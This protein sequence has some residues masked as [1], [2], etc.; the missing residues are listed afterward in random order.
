MKLKSVVE[1]LTKT[2]ILEKENIATPTL[3]EQELAD[4]DSE[5]VSIE[6]ACRSLRNVIQNKR[7]LGLYPKSERTMQTVQLVE[8]EK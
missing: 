5:I 7:S 2:Y 4:L 8:K 3:T 6:S 1:Y